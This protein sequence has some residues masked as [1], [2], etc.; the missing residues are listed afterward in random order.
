MSVLFCL[1]SCNPEPT[2]NS[3]ALAQEMADRKIKRV[4]GAQ[5]ASVVDEWGASIVASAQKALAA[6]LA[7]NPDTSL[8]RPDK[9]TSVQKLEKLYA[10]KIELVGA[11]DV[12]SPILPAKEREVLDAYLY[13]A[14][15]KLPQ[16][17][18]VQKIADS[19]FVYNAAVPADNPI[20]KTCSDNA[21]LP[22]V[23]WR[24]VFNR[25]EVI[26]RINTKALEK[27]K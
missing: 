12:K 9:L 19:L 18:N 27:K 2:Q 24:I 16:S 11:S 26:R 6:E 5:V 17:T 3:K 22:F 25:K 4:T 1:T 21:A 15:Q 20:C 7:K 14:E 13:N 23:V 8:C 10:A